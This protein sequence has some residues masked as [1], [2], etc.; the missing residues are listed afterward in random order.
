MAMQQAQEVVEKFVK[1]WLAKHHPHADLVIMAGSYGR[2][3]REGNYQPLSSSD[4]D[5]VIIYSDLEKGGFRSAAQSFTQEDVGT[6]LGEGK[7]RT[8]MV[9][10]NVHDLA[11]LHY[12]DK[13]VREHTH[14]AFMN[15]MIDEGYVLTDKLGIS[16]V[17]KQKALKF[18][19][20]GPAPTPAPRWQEEVARLQTYLADIRRADDTETKRFIGALGMIHVCEYALG[21]HGY[22]RSGSNQAYRRLAKY[23]PA[24]EAAITDAFST[25]LREGDDAKVQSLLQDYI[26]RG[27]QRLPSLPA[28]NPPLPYPVDKHVAPQDLAA[29]RNL[30]LKFM[31]EHLCEALETSQKR[32]ELAHLEN[33][34][35]MLQFVKTNLQ[36]SSGTP[37]SIEGRAAMDYLNDKLPDLMPQALA[38]LDEKTFQPLRDT[39]EKSLAH[40]QGMHYER[41][42]NLMAEDLA[43]VNAVN[44]A[45]V[46]KRN[47]KPGYKI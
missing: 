13:V 11:S 43:R 29:I 34:S 41:L 7:P 12:H 20:E 16:E 5:L 26:A 35:A 10:T 1:P 47:F 23:F 22:W 44:P 40:M 45:A 17:L 8:M 6:A 32:G 9:D 21:L 4:I 38:A 3:M 18:L 46:S 24:E 15:V 31:T 42:D 28:E 39:A 14:F 37:G 33:L 25:L 27:N 2:A 36:L 19:E 30:F